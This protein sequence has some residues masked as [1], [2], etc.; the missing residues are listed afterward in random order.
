MLSDFKVSELSLLEFTACFMAC[1]TA[2]HQLKRAEPY[3]T[4]LAQ[5]CG[6]DRVPRSSFLPA[7]LLD[8]HRGQRTFP[9]VYL[10]RRPFP[11]LLSHPELSCLKS[12][13]LPRVHDVFYLPVKTGPVLSTLHFPP[14]PHPYFLF[15]APFLLF[16]IEITPPQSQL[17]TKVERKILQVNLGS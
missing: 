17:Y 1:P 11:L 16:N 4:C 7:S 13:S 3:P 5:D 6:A 14:S 12:L 8:L 15:S 9:A 2:E 10:Q